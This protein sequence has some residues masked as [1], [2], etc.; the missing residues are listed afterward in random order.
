LRWDK[1]GVGGIAEDSRRH[2]PAGIG[3]EAAKLAL[4]VH[5]AKTGNVGRHGALD[6]ALL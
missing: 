1:F 6:K 4:A 2:R 5:I 3:I